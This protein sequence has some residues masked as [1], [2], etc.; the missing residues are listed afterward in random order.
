VKP[1]G[2]ELGIL[3]WERQ[4]Q[5][6]WGRERRKLVLGAEYFPFIIINIGIFKE[7]WGESLGLLM[8]QEQDNIRK[9]K[10]IIEFEI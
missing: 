7:I 8:K 1:A 5:T 9:H 10:G 3:S 2:I 4:N 6:R